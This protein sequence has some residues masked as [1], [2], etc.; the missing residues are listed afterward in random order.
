METSMIE[1]AIEAVYKVF[2]EMLHDIHLML[3]EDI[4]FLD[5]LNKPKYKP[6]VI[7][8]VKEL[9]SFDYKR[10]IMYYRKIGR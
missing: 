5:N 8:E 4:S 1:D 9:K 6:F 2:R 7:N 10:K 3:S